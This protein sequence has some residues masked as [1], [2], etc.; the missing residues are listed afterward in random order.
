MRS[1]DKLDEHIS[2][3][4]PHMPKSAQSPPGLE[5]EKRSKQK[6]KLQN[7]TPRAPDTLRT[8]PH[9]Y[10]PAARRAPHVAYLQGSGWS[11]GDAGM[12]SEVGIRVNVAR[13]PPRRL[14]LSEPRP[15]QEQH[16]TTQAQH[17]EDV[18]NMSGSARARSRSTNVGKHRPPSKDTYGH[19]S[20]EGVI[21][22]GLILR[23]CC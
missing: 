23:R 4:K 3:V 21:Y 8:E 14:P 18:Q 5:A 10:V 13:D 15:P 1:V 22:E 6:K 11:C 2:T 20:E 17:L 12:R 16:F 7:L 9:T 19:P